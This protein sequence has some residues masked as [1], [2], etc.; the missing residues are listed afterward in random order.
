MFYLWKVL[1]LPFFCLFIVASFYVQA[2]RDTFSVF[3]R[4]LFVTG[5]TAAFAGGSLIY[6][7]EVWYSQYNTGR[8]HFFNDNAEWLQMDKAGHMYSSYQSGRLLMSA[9]D[10]AGFSSRQKLFIGGSAGFVY[11][12]AI[13]L[14]DGYSRGWGFSWGDMLANFSG[15]VLAMGQEAAWGEQKLQ[16]KFSYFP[17]NIAQYNPALLGENSYTRVLK[18]YNAQSYWLCF[19]PLVF[20]GK[21]K[22]RFPAWLNLAIGYG[23]Y[24]MTGGHGN[25]I[26]I[27]DENGMPLHFK[28]E[29][30]FLLSLDLDLTRIRTRSRLLKGL[31]S[32]VNAFKIPAPA[33]SA[34]AGGVKFY[35][36]R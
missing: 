35:P 28:R 19:S 25:N 20:A 5:A 1:R 15:A 32:V 24:G 17:S 33:I 10:W 14:M 8:F 34:G 29:R 7:N 9:F 18:D 27:R 22:G 3:Q 26:E 12:G 23:A 2:Q 21:T 30:L 6:L 4:K 31:F 13:E 16:L 36:V 11:L